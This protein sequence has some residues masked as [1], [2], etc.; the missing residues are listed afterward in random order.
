VIGEL[1]DFMVQLL[2]LGA[3]RPALQKVLRPLY[4]GDRPLRVLLSGGALA[5][6]L[7]AAGCEVYEAQKGPPPAPPD[8]ICASGVRGDLRAALQEWAEQVRPGGMVVL[9]TRRGHPT[10]ARLCA[11]LLHAGLV[12]PVQ[13]AAG[14]SVITAGRAAL[15]PSSA[16]HGSA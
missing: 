9:V 1:L 4:E 10:R 8:V 13:R 16:S 14:F 5:R 6:P 3:D 7:R 2:H 15:P 12:E 11:A